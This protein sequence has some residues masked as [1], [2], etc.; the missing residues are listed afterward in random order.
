MFV[1]IVI[2]IMIYFFDLSYKFLNTLIV[3]KIKLLSLEH[4]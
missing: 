2:S 4:T 3:D 1:S